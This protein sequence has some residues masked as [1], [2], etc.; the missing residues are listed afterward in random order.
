MAVDL[1]RLK[2]RIENSSIPKE[3]KLSLEEFD[4]ELS[5]LGRAENII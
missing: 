2:G 3:N 5:V 1:S 4:K